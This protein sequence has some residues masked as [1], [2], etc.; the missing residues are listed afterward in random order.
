MFIAMNPCFDSRPLASGTRSILD[1]S[2]S[3][4][5][6]HGDSAALNQQV[7]PLHVLKQFKGGVDVGVGHLK[8]QCW[9]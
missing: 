5:M 4:V 7:V 2:Q 3:V 9:S 8:A 1:F 6:C